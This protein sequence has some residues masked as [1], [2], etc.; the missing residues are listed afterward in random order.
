[1]RAVLL[2]FLTLVLPVASP[3]QSIVSGSGRIPM[4]A[5]VR[6]GVW[7]DLIGVALLVLFFGVR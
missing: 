7:M 6:V 2:F 3:M 5:M 1:V 4:R